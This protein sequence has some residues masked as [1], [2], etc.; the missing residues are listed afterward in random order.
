MADARYVGRQYCVHPDLDTTVAIRGRAEA[1]VGFTKTWALHGGA[2]VGSGLLKS[3]RA[4]I[5]VDN[6]TDATVYD[7]CGLPRAG[8]TLRLALELR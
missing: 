4:M 6:L 7:Q 8:R 2:R 3:L 1:D 5:G